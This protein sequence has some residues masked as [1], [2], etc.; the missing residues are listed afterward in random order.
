MKKFEDT[1]VFSI[2]PV[3]RRKSEP[4]EIKQSVA[5]VGEKTTMESTRGSC[6]I[7]GASTHGT[8]I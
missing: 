5:L 8:T 4:L 2:V 7:R 1:G 6:S 3:Q